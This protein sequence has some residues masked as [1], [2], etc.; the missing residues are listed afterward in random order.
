MLK[1][2]QCGINITRSGHISPWGVKT[3]HVSLLLKLGGIKFETNFVCKSI[4]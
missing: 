1:H 4:C 2:I 3:A